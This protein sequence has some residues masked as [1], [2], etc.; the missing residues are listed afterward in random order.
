[1]LV[2]DSSAVSFLAERTP[3]A[4]AVLSKLVNEGAW[5]PVV[6]SVVLVECLTEHG[7]RDAAT[8]RVL[9]ECDIRELLPTRLVRR[10]AYLRTG[11]RRGSAVDAIVVATAEPGG[12][13]LT[14]DH[15]DFA[16]LAELAGGVLVEII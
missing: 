1:M 11:A 8:H 5:P 4:K 6:P 14:A 15:K 9:N 2:L 3:R 13:T 7:Q 12:T 10:A 16:A